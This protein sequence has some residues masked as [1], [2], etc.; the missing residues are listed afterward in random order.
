MIF[1][2]DVMI[3][4]PNAMAVGLKKAIIF[5]REAIVTGLEMR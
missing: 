5:A 4:G 3:M 2:S 1:L